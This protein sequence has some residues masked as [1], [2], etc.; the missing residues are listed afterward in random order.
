MSMGHEL[1]LPADLDGDVMPARWEVES[2][3]CRCDCLAAFNDEEE[4][5]QRVRQF[6]FENT[7]LSRADKDKVMWD[8][9]SGMADRKGHITSC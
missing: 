2:C 6:Q 5:K 8:L 1:V 9:I 7:T 3:G 4:L